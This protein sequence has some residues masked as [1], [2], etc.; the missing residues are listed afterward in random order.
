MSNEQLNNPIKLHLQYSTFNVKC[1]IGSRSNNNNITYPGVEIKTVNWFIIIKFFYISLCATMK[2][3]TCVKVK[4]TVKLYGRVY[5]FSLPFVFFYLSWWCLY[6]LFPK[7]W[8]DF[9]RQKTKT[10]KKRN[11]KV[12]YLIWCAIDTI[13]FGI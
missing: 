2:L 9:L 7:E 11:S 5:I 1:L 8:Y 3:C 12:F 6:R 13:K 10:Q 4:S